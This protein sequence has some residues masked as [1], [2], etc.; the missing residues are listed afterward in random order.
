MNLHRQLYPDTTPW[1]NCVQFRDDSIEI[2][3]TLGF[4]RNKLTQGKCSLNPLY[5][6]RYS[7][8]NPAVIS[9]IYVPRADRLVARVFID[10]SQYAVWRSTKSEY[11]Y[12]H[13]SLD[14]ILTECRSVPPCNLVPQHNFE[15]EIVINGMAYQRWAPFIPILQCA[16]AIFDEDSD[17]F[18]IETEGAPTGSDVYLEEWCFE[19]TTL[20]SSFMCYVKSPQ[21]NMLVIDDGVAIEG[22]HWNQYPRHLLSDELRMGMG[23]TL[24]AVNLKPP[25]G[26]RI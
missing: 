25:L 26:A 19:N 18:D 15:D 1:D 13:T 22:K 2:K 17:W 8:P 6:R 16:D 5:C 12:L 3:K 4:W 9:A 23:N 21:P 24:D 7:I 20:P 10:G 14:A 11:S